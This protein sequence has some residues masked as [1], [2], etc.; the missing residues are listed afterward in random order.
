MIIFGKLVKKLFES[1]DR[2]FAVYQLRVH[3][4][5][6]YNAVFNAAKPHVEAPPARKTVELKLNGNWKTHPKYGK[7]FVFGE[8]ERADASMKPKE[9]DMDVLLSAKQHAKM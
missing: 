3:G 7:Q 5:D 8:Y 4:G 2:D 1:A 9:K 6:F